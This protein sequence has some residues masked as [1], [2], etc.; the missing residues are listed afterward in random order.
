V[1]RSLNE[2]AYQEVWRSKRKAFVEEML[3]VDGHSVDRLV[4]LLREPRTDL[5]A[6]T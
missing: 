4:L 6:R 2:T 3:V 1:E 5:R